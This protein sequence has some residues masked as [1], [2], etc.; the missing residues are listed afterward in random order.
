MRRGQRRVE[1]VRWWASENMIDSQE[2]KCDSE[3]GLA[4]GL[5]NPW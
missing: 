1:P 2:H 3:A 5:A 4:I